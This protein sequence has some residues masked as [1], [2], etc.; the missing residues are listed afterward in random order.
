MKW[1]EVWIALGDNSSFIRTFAEQEDS[2]NNAKRS[3]PVLLKFEAKYITRLLFMSFSYW[4]G[5][6]S[7]YFIARP[8][9]NLHLGNASEQRCFDKSTFIF[10]FVK[11]SVKSS[12][13]KSIST[14]NYRR[15]S[16]Y[17][18]ILHILH[19]KLQQIKIMSVYI[20]HAF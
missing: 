13:L 12:K 2:R 3:M 16:H 4:L 5:P 14:K 8:S 7:Y 20:T 11:N 19:N 10:R 1:S 18:H 9:I 6:K 17:S 15:K